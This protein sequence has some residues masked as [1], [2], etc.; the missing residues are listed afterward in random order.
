MG[1]II[2]AVFGV[3]VQTIVGTIIAEVIGSYLRHLRE[4]AQQNR[5]AKQ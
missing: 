1:T 4:R 3:I 5:A 2:R